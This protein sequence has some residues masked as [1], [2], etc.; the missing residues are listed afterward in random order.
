MWTF[1]LPKGLE[2]IINQNLLKQHPNEPTNQNLEQT[3]QLLTDEHLS[4]Y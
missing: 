4:I 2:K 3:F 1:F